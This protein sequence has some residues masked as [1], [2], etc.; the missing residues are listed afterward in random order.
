M[1]NWGVGGEQASERL[2]H[3]KTPWEPRA[4]IVAC[5]VKSVCFVKNDT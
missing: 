4:G 2:K 5:L 3:V 1:E